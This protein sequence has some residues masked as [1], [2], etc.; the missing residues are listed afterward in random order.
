MTIYF[1]RYVHSKFIKV[2]SLNYHEVMG[3]IEKHEEKKYL[4]VDDYILDKV[5]GKIKKIMNTE[6][7]D[8]TV[9]L[10]DTDGKLPDDITL[11]ML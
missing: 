6:K 1:T 5:L 4:M 9:I 7:I 8:N 10:I 2:L 11:E 3:K